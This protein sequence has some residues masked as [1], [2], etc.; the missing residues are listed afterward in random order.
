M[1]GLN[2]FEIIGPIVSKP[3]TAVRGNY[4]L[5]NII[6]R[7]ERTGKDKQ[8]ITTDIPI[9]LF[10]DHT[11]KISL[12]DCVYIVGRLDSREYNGKIYVDV[13]PVDWQII[14]THREPVAPKIERPAINETRQT[15]ISQPATSEQGPEEDIPF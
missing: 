10:G 11:G 2:R 7:T 15:D 13:K 8:I 6:V 5:T 9:S 3:V 1:N 12:G 14:V 4:A